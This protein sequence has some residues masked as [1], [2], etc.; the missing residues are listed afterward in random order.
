MFL[1]DLRRRELSALPE[2]KLINNSLDARN[3]ISVRRIRGGFS[4]FVP[5]KIKEHLSSICVGLSR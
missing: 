2:R 3:R 4:V 5:G 1:I